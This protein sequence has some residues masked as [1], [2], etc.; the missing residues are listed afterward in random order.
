MKIKIVKLETTTEKQIAEFVASMLW[1]FLENASEMAGVE[2]G[3]E[4]FKFPE[5]VADVKDGTLR[6]GADKWVEN[7]LDAVLYEFDMA[8]DDDF[9]SFA[10]VEDDV[11]PRPAFEECKAMIARV[12]GADVEEVES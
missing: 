6:V 9:R 12:Q 5:F 4:D 11:T 3:Y 7:Y 1:G 2:E 8:D 10:R